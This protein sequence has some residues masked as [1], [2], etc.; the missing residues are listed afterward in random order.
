MKRRNPVA[1]KT[2]MVRT[3]GLYVSVK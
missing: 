1:G 2:Q 3:Y